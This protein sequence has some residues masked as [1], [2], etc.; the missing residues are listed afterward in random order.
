MEGLGK[1]RPLDFQGS[2]YKGRPLDYLVITIFSLL[3]PPKNPVFVPQCLCRK[4][5]VGVFANI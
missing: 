4:Y 1:P 3:L 5:K 2:N